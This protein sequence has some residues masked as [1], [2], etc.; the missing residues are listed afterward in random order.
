MR[1]SS[2]AMLVPVAFVA[3]CAASTGIL[4][5]ARTLGGR[6]AIASLSAVCFRAILLLQAGELRVR[7]RRL[8]RSG[9]DKGGGGRARPCARRRSLARICRGSAP[10]LV[11]RGGGLLPAA[12]NGSATTRK[13]DCTRKNISLV[14][15]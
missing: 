3:G 15:G 9:S 2:F 14:K 4:R 7:R 13:L 5:R 11:G 12:F 10:E 8:L 1:Y 6:P